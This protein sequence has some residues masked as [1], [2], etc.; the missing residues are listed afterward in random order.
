MSRKSYFLLFVSLLIGIQFGYSQISSFPYSENFDE[1]TAPALPTGWS[2]TTLRLATGDFT[3][4]TSS[5]RPGSAP[6]A[7]MST[8]S[9]INQALTSP[10]FDFRGK[11]LDKLLFYSS[12]SSTHIAGLLVE[13]SLDG[14]S[15]FPIA[16][17]DTI[18]NP[19]VTTFVLT[20]LALPASLNNQPN[21]RIRWRLVA[22]ASGTSGTFRIDDVSLTIQTQYDL[23]ITK[24]TATPLFPTMLESVQLSATVKNQSALSVSG[25]TVDFFRDT[26]SNGIADR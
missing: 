4:T 22:G 9:T 24:L 3:T 16:L 17:S 25:Y 15:T 10:Q 20:T 7:V 11:T 8:N 13:A 14:G 6:N 5:P 1:V 12:R 26:N 19:G 2:T 18:K 21:V 23:A